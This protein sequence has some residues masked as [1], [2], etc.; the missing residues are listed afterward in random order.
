MSLICRI[1]NTALSGLESFVLGH[2]QYKRLDAAIAQVGRISMKGEAHWEDKDGKHWALSNAGVLRR[3]KM[4]SSSTELLIRRIRW[5]Q[6]LASSPL[7][8]VAVFAA[9]FGDC[10][11]DVGKEGMKCVEG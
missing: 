3:W 9:L 6:A 10:K 7:D 5:Y 8:G 4:V 1:Q 2:A 11:G